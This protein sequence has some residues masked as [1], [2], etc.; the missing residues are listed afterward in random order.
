MNKV[1]LA[2]RLANQLQISSYE[3]I[4]YL[5]TLIREIET[6]LA[7]GEPI[8][9]QKFGTF[10]PWYQTPRPGRNPKNGTPHDIPART[11]VKFKPGTGLLEKMNPKKI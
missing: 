11:S 8:V 2:H 10:A 5:N 1:Q 6:V 4:D 3:S 7:E 9:F